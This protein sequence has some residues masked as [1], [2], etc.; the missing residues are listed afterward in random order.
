MRFG[1]RLFLRSHEPFTKI[2]RRAQ[3]CEELGFDSVFVDDHLLYGTGQAAA[4]DPFT[5]LT[6]L[7]LQTRSIRLGVLVSDLVRRHPA[8]MAQTVGTMSRILPNRFFLGLGAGD[9]MNQT[10][11]GLSAAHRFGLLQEGLKVAKMLWTSTITR[12]AAFRG[13]FFSLKKAYLQTDHSHVPPIYLGAFGEK[14]LRLTGEQADG[15]VPH[16]HTP[17]TYRK[18]LDKICRAAKHVRRQWDEFDPCYCTLVSVARKRE[19]ANQNV[20]G[21]SK[22][23]LALI[24]EGLRK[25]DP[26]AKHPGHIWEKLAHPKEQRKAI[27]RIAESIPERAAF[28]TVIHGTPG[29]CIEQIARYEKAGCRELML[30]FVPD[31]GL[32]S[33]KRLIPLIRLFSRKVAD[34]FREL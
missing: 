16:C 4:P 32:W 8:I 29:D 10:P 6:A 13:Q 17:E 12:P 2:V 33:T 7:G 1:C 15:W 3:F 31:G 20:L 27:R 25:V 11:F 34:Y 14:M 30:T 5:T 22:Y 9:P 23:F 18:D 26:T 24:P 28:D 21:P 19:N